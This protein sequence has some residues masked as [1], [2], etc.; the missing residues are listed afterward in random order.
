MA[1]PAPRGAGVALS[2]RSLPSQH[3]FADSGP[4]LR[5]PRPARGWVRAI[6]DALGMTT[7]QLAARLG[8]KQPRV[9]ELER[10]EVQGTITLHSLERAAEA[11][12]CKVVYMLVPHE[13]L[14]LTLQKRAAEIARQQLAAVDQT[15][16][17]EAQAVTSQAQQ[18]AALQ[19]LAEA[20]L[21]RPARLWDEP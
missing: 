5:A 3:S 20:L 6:R 10:G 21:R 11:M 4:L 17:L 12:G 19:Q 18:Q 13:P 16:Q 15:M 2:V 14:T 1:T 9:V 8:V 7:A